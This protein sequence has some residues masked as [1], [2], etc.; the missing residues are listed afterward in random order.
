MTTLT[1]RLRQ[2]AVA[3][4]ATATLSGCA[5]TSVGDVLGGV[6]GGGQQQQQNQALVEVQGVDTRNQV[7]QVRT[8]DGRTGS[9]Y[10]DQNTQVIHQQQRHPVT[11]L[12]RGDVVV[13][14]LEQ[15]SQ[16]QTYTPRIDVRQ[17]VQ[18]RTGQTTGATGQ[19]FELYGRA[20]NIDVER[21]TFQVET[22]QG[23]YLVSLPYNADAATEDYFRRMR[24]GDIVRL[25]GVMTGQGRVELYR[26]R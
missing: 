19:R 22:Q 16:G 12:E 24:T 8:E 13:M 2:V 10:Y 18:E 14:Q 5:G 26:F 23:T 11:A 4:L 21:G 7:I 3:A 6:L 17:T 15:T 25:E 9:V 1:M 20:S